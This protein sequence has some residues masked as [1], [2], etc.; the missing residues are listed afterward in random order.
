MANEEKENVEFKVERAE[1]NLDRI[2][3]WVWRHNYRT[4]FLFGAVTLMYGSSFDVIIGLTAYCWPIKYWA[5]FLF[6]LITALYGIIV[7]F[8]FVS[9]KPDVKPN[10]ESYVFFWHDLSNGTVIVRERGTRS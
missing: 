1:A 5:L 3:A 10:K 6:A 2:I 4:A 7:Y 8:L 9:I